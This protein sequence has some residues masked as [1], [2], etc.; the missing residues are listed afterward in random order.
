MKANVEEHIGVCLH[1]WQKKDYFHI[2]KRIADTHNWLELSE[3]NIHPP[4]DSCI[5]NLCVR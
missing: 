3:G 1:G 2:F 5:N 4:T